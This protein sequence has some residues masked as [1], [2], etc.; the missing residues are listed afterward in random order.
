MKNERAVW[1]Y[2]NKRND[3]GIIYILM[4]LTQLDMTE[5]V[6]PESLYM[7]VEMEK[8]KNCQLIGLVYLIYLK[9]SIKIGHNESFQVLWVVR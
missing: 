9:T 6:D 2:M 3:E 7:I 5:Q 8:V 1:E 4:N